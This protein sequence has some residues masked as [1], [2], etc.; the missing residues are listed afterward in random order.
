MLK[1]LL[2]LIFTALVLTQ[3]ITFP[4]IK[5][6]FSGDSE[7]FSQELTAFM[8]TTLS[9]ENKATLNLFLEKWDS[10]GFTAENK[11]QLIEISNRLASRQ[12]RP[13]PHF[14]Q[15]I[16]TLYDFSEREN[17]SQLIKP[18]LAGL[19][20]MISKPELTNDNIL[21]YIQNS[22][23]LI[24]KNILYS[25]AS[26]KWVIK[27]SE[28]VFAYDSLF[29]AIVSN[30][31][32]TCNSQGDST[33]IYNA[34]G[35]FYPFLQQ[36]RGTRGT[37]TWE[38]AG[39]PKDYAFAQLDDYTINTTKNSFTA[40][41]AKL[42]H[43]NYFSQ[44]VLG[45]LNDQAS[46][47]GSREKSIFPR[48]ETYTKNF[49][50]DNV[51]KDVGYE[52]G[53]AF[54]G[55]N[56]K[57]LGDNANPAKVTLYRNKKPFIK[58][59]SKEFV[60]SGSGLTGQE[61]SATIYLESDSIF[62]TNLGFSF[63]SGARQVNL[64]R[65]NNPVSGSPYYDTFHK[66][67]MYFESLSWDMNSSK[68][69]ISR[70]RG[71]A[72]GQAL[73]QSVS[74][75]NSD[76]FLSL[77]NL[78]EYHPLTRLK[79]FSEWFYSQTF[80]VSE[81]AKW[82]NKPEN[83]VIGMCIDM[84]NKGFVFYDAANNEVTLKPKINDYIDAYVGKIDY[85][86]ISIYSETKAPVD[87]AILDLNDYGLTVNGV[88]NIFLSD[89]QKV[90]VY[91]Y[92][93]QLTVIRNRSFKFDGVVEA[94]LFTIY[95]H[96]FQFSYDTFKIRLG[97]IDSIKVAVETD[98]RDAYG[99]P[100]IQ[101]VS[102]LIQLS[103]GELYIDDPKNKSGLRSL[104]QYP[105]IN[106]TTWSYIFYDRIPGL[107]DVYKKKD[108]YFK[109]DP[110][111][112]ENIDHYTYEDFSLSGE[113]YA[114]NIL[115]PMK[116][117]LTVQENNSLGFKMNIPPDG[118]DVYD[119]KGKFYDFL[120]M[121]DKGLT[122]RGTLKHLT[123]TTQSDDYKFFP[124]SLLTQANTFNIQNDGS[125]RYPELKSED[126]KIKW[127]PWQDEWYAYNAQGK[128][129][130]MFDNGTLLN[131]GLKLS[132]ADLS[133]EGIINT[134]TSR[135]NSNQF[136]FNSNSIRADTADYNLKSASTSGYAFVAENANTDINFKTEISRF[137]LNTDSSVVKFPEIQYIC[138]MTDFEYNMQTRILNMEQ[139]GKNTDKALISPDKLLA[140]KHDQLDKPTFFATNSLRDTISFTSLKARY[141]VDK[142][143][144]EAEDISYIPI[145][146][147]LIQPENGKITINRRAKID[148]LSNAYVAVN[149]RY[150]LHGANI[151]IESTKRYSGSGIYDYVDE[152][153]EV[154]PISFPEITVDTLTTS[155]RGFIPPEQKFMLSPA[156]T[157]SGDVFL[158]AKADQLMFTGA[159]GI[160][161]DCSKIKSYNVKFKSYIDPN[162][163]MIP[164]SE[165]PRDSNDNLLYTGS[166]INLESAS[167]YPAFLSQQGAWTDVG[168]V[169]ASGYLYYNKAKGNYQI[170][171][172][173]K[174]IDPSLNG[175]M[176]SLNRSLCTL[177]GEGSLN[178]GANFDLVKM[179]SAG[180]VVQTGDSGKVDL[181][182][183]LAINFYFSDDALKIMSDD[184]RLIPSLKTVSMNSDFLNKGMKDLLGTG[185]AD[186]LKTETDLFGVSRNLPKEFNF[187]L[188]LNE[189]NLRWNESTSSFRSSGKIGLGFILNQPI[190]VYLDGYIEI[191]RRRSGDM[192]DIYLKANESTWYYFSY[193]RG[194]MMA[195]SSNS[196]FNTLISSLKL[197]ERRH[198]DSSVRVPYT[199]MIAVEDRLSRF[200]R[201]MREGSADDSALPGDGLIR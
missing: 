129:F 197:K 196:N 181:K 20:E 39:Y 76:Y 195:Q 15:F 187:E 140:I 18:W 2:T 189:V 48:F 184:I 64:F 153:R 77:M 108:F 92:N 99:N 186:Q 29:K 22:S 11:S 61:T 159:A 4:Q 136:T 188:L 164:V 62:H 24:T 143:F 36:F 35:T 125:G 109:V 160:V 21:R 180:N 19:G 86:V 1:R 137:H 132:T 85:D 116:Q 49:K 130:E 176:V 14:I 165:K 179:S 63:N 16:N 144:I 70:P 102:S 183:I 54:E 103:T 80:P 42:T 170:S 91:P 123:S 192:I 168:I 105:I 142:E 94:G 59:S 110:F 193:F 169:N 199:Y 154:M 40:D 155:A 60:F 34:S 128:N 167:I 67:D 126:V 65:T 41:S 27:N 75:F 97:T 171:S 8:G 26:A 5:P 175:N 115:K 44:P 148:R 13:V 25:S 69:I 141:N 3:E 73:F 107:R 32:L 122:G 150:L 74:F 98:K 53:L 190:N 112:F 95:G 134:S 156:F 89:S 101:T 149:N 121:S 78:D 127:L 23:L 57:G 52:G 147:A 161:N 33:E 87:N 174:M 104:T 145:A 83:L 117:Y 68:I 7:K 131:G 166:Y 163:V 157:F 173:E 31:T 111:A 96:N 135:I 28:P 88:S 178:L 100:I 118:I 200:L 72:L 106:S 194:V 84:A 12:M 45:T 43:K 191:Q 79:Q 151:D 10:S 172:A 30:A 119:G 138:T 152:S 71:A 139:R 185:V 201:R 17:T 158:S 120:Q 6:P 50:I 58:I 124:D 56:V 51:Y 114:G 177:S 66:L 38:K 47:F 55:A 182:A 198:P 113:F 9:E 146:D 90:A 93:K 37:V 81:F 82:L 133:G 46:S 162:N